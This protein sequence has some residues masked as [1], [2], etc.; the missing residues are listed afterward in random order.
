MSINKLILIIG[1]LLPPFFSVFAQQNETLSREQFEKI[2]PWVVV[3]L[4]EAYMLDYREYME[5]KNKR[6]TEKE[7]TGLSSFQ[8]NFTDISKYEKDADSLLGVVQVFIEKGKNGWSG[9]GRNVFHEYRNNYYTGLNDSDYSIRVFSFIPQLKNDKLQN[10]SMLE[11]LTN[12]LPNVF[13]EQRKE[14]SYAEK[15]DD[16]SDSSN[17]NTVASQSSAYSSKRGKSQEKSNTV[18]VKT[19]NWY[20]SEEKTEFF[21]S[22]SMWMYLLIFILTV[23]ILI[24]LVRNRNIRAKKVKTT[25][26]S[27]FSKGNDPRTLKRE[28]ENLRWQ[29]KQLE[30]KNINLKDQLENSPVVERTPV[31]TEQEIEL[32]VNKDNTL[33]D[34]K[35]VATPNEIYLPF[36]YE[37]RKFYSGNQS[38]TPTNDSFYKVILDDSLQSGKLFIYPSDALIKTA[39]N[40]HE[41][42]LKSVCEYSN[43]LESFHNN[44]STIAPG[45]V[46]LEGDDWAVIEKIK[47]KFT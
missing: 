18:E 15:N 36:P 42:F 21:L 46:K 29:I 4:T 41:M 17:P 2:G 16:I 37:D 1:I 22:S 11:F 33:P 34:Q 12:E 44:I 24:L 19:S 23:V 35:I 27:S 26:R 20:K 9:L 14:E 31:N 7:I 13:L 8:E 38:N 43:A 47:I 5:Q 3:K 30:N 28:I 32:D 25:K 10:S 40:S 45:K 39:F 6:L